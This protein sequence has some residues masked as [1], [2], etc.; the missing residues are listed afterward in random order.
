MATLNRKVL[1]FGVFMVTLIVIFLML[2]RFGFFSEYGFTLAAVISLLIS[3][4]AFLL[5]FGEDVM[6]LLGKDTTPKAQVISPPRISRAIKK[7]YLECYGIHVNF[8]PF[9]I[10]EPELKGGYRDPFLRGLVH[11]PNG[12]SEQVKV[13]I[14]R[15]IE[16]VEA[17]LFNRDTDRPITY[18]QKEEIQFSPNIIPDP[19]AY[20]KDLPPELQEEIITGK[21]KKKAEKEIESA[22][23]DEEEKKKEKEAE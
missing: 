5:I 23:E 21:A 6:K 7:H 11:L 3:T 14:F 12:E 22:G 1:A 15:G 19:F 9:R 20:L 13:P 2:F 17:G 18:D 16:C 4:V 8:E 10:V